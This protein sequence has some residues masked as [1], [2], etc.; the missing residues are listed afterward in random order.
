MTLSTAQALELAVLDNAA[1]CVAMWRAHG[2]E[3]HRGPGMVMCVGQPPAYYPNV[4]TTV[5]GVDD[6]AQKEILN[7][8]A[9]GF[10]VPG[11]SIKDSFA[12]LDLSICGYG[13]LFTAKWL[14]RAPGP[15]L[16]PK[17]DWRMVETT[18]ELVAWESALR[19]T[20]SDGRPTFVEP[21]LADVSVGIFAGWENGQINTGVV[22][23]P[24][25]AHVAGLSN[26][27]GQQCEAVAIATSV[28]PD[29]TLVGYERGEEL[30]G[31]KTLGFAE[32]GDLAVWQSL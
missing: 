1:W 12:Q 25:D 19:R 31:L 29:R 17:L 3:V 4:V 13:V 24:S 9:Q 8:L 10:G 20:T 28:F 11:I 32:T 22:L 30:E 6:A 2:L 27:F 15:I 26:I 21:L 14:A 16:R 5:S 23:T 18:A 7:G